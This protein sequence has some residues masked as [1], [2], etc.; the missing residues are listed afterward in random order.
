MRILEL[1]NYTAGACGV[2]KRVL[3][4][5][6]MLSKKGHIVRIFSSNH[7]KGKSEICPRTEKIKSVQINRFPAIKLGGEGFLSWNFNEEAKKF[8]PD[9]IIAHS[10]RQLHT[11]KALKLAGKLKVPCLLVTHA[12][13]ERE[14]SRTFIQ[15]IIVEFYDI[16][17]GKKKI[18]KFD[19]VL[20]ITPWERKHIINLGVPESKIFYSPNGVSEEFFK[21]SKNNSKLSILYSG[22]ISPIK[23]LEV[24]VN[25]MPLVNK[26][27]SLLIYG[28]AENVY[29]EKLNGIIK[30]QNLQNKVSIVN[31][32]YDL[33]DQLKLLDNAEI[34]VLPSKSEGMPQALIEA[35]ARGKIVLGSD[36]SSIKSIVHNGKN[37][38]TFRQGDSKDLADK[39][40]LVFSM[41]NSQRDKIRKEATS[42]VKRFKWPLI[43]EDIENLLIKLTN[44][45]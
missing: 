43:I 34:F 24:L 40:N 27:A 42:S 41:K 15:N 1:T 11:T 30:K 29:L 12:P 23:N 22:R 18:A 36:I 10:Y 31:K 19:M 44:K 5:S 14:K 13:F 9:I 2:G 4:E 6:Q 32:E 45:T 20:A 3:R 25:S 28:P 37:G 21:N 33:K 39:L 26:N 7:I 35:M 8:N 38:F 17:I 16:F